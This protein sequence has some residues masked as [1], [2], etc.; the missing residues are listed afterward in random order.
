MAVIWQ[1]RMKN[2]ETQSYLGERAKEEMMGR[3]YKIQYAM[4]LLWDKCEELHLKVVC[5]RG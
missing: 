3:S 2:G 5:C 4:C 1:L